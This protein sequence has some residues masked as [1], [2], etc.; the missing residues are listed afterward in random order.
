M[1]DFKAKMHQFRFDDV[2]CKGIFTKYCKFRDLCPLFTL[3]VL[4][5]SVVFPLRIKPRHLGKL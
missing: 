3:G 1:S 5:K 4:K 2:H